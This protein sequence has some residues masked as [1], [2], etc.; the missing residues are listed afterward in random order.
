MARKTIR[1]VE[2]IHAPTKRTR[3][4]VCKLVACGLNPE[5][6]S[7]VLGCSEHDI[8]LHY[9]EEL[10]HG[11]SMVTALVGGAMLKNALRGD[12]NAQRAW[13]QMRARW[14]IPQHVELTGRDGGP[15]QVEQR[16]QLV[17]RVLELAS[18]RA[19]NSQEDPVPGS[20]VQ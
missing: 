7:F 4:Q 10:K 16:R 19:K 12:T 6:V 18:G 15:I 13:L 17:A 3:E 1:V 14:T 5:E 8:R 2:S 11:T 20:S 9:E